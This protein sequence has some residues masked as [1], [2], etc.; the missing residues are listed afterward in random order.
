MLENDKK[1]DISLIVWCSE[2]GNDLNSTI[3][4]KCAGAQSVFDVNQ[5]AAAAASATGIRY[6]GLANFSEFIN[7]PVLHHNFC[8]AH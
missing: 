3:S 1:K 7:I 5:R 8:S 6:V 2:C 4:S